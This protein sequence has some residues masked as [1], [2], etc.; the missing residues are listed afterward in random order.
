MVKRVTGPRY[1]LSAL[2][3]LVLHVQHLTTPNSAAPIPTADA[4]VD[5]TRALG[6]LQIDTLHVVNRAHYVTVWARFGSYPLDLLDSLLYAPDQRRLYEG[7]GHAACII[8]LED[9]RFHRWRS[10]PQRSF[11]PSFEQWL[12]KPGHQALVDETLA[13][14]R[15]EGG[16]RVGDFSTPDAPRGV[17]YDWKP[18]KMALE[19]LF[20]RGDLMVADRVHF[21]RV[22]DVRERVLPEWVDVTPVAPEAGRRFC[23]E[24]AARALGVFELRH[25]T[26]YAYMRATPAR[27]E[28]KA[29]VEDGT[30]VAIDGESLHGT[31]TWWI[32]RDHLP[33]LEQAADGAL[34]AA[35][36]TFIAPFDSLLW[37]PDRDERLWGFRQLLECYKPPEERVYGYFCLP[38]LHRD[39]LV[40]RFDPKLDRKSGVLHLNALYLEPGI[41]PDES[42]VTGVATALRDFLSWHGAARLDI[43]TSDPTDFSDRLLRAL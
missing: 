19:V 35:R 38:I 34:T 15:A 16:L 6:Y 14:I 33:L 30:L 28:I 7:W 12:S 3:A 4:I 10:D 17:W 23:L 41:E 40:G 1:P 42:L 20:A 13:R 43:A 32:H 18:S 36:T 27:S 11:N 2:R 25:L 29:L 26:F 9:Y 39:R 37:A 8:P 22:Y 21:Q 5:L 24:Q 31:A